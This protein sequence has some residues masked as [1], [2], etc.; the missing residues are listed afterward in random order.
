MKQISLTPAYFMRTFGDEEVD[1]IDCESG[2]FEEGSLKDILRLYDT[3]RDLCDPVL[4][5]KVCSSLIY[6]IEMD[7]LLCQDWPS[8]DTFRGGK[9]A[10]VYEEFEDCLPFPV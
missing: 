7:P 10:E 8:R 1:L 5:V 9:F 6:V 2:R 4:K 3:P